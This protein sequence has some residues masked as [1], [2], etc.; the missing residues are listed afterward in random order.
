M[1]ADEDLK[2]L[3]LYRFSS[4]GVAL[5]NTLSSLVDDKSLNQDEALTVLQD[6]DKV[7]A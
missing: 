1:S 2:V 7:G 3:E 5:Q 4:L 6:F